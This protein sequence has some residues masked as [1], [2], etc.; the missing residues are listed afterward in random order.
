M[1][2]I[3]VAILKWTFRIA[4]IIAV[5]IGLSVLI[6]V[7][8]NYLIIGY[9]QSVVA[10]I[11]AIIQIWL[12]FNLNIVLLWVTVS[13]SAFIVYKLSALSYVLLNTFVGKN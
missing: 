10:D 1:G 2:E 3:V 8:I 4:F 7:I 11:F 12:P 6:S 9:N 5:A 13:A